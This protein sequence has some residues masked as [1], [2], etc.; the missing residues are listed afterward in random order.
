MP[1]KTSRTVRPLHQPSRGNPEGGPIRAGADVPIVAVTGF[2]DSGKTT[3]V[4]YIVRELSRRGYRVGTFKHCHYGYDLDRPGKDSYRHRQAG[5]A[6][7]VLI[8]PNGFALLSGPP[9]DEDPRVLA[10]W[11]LPDAHLILAEG[12]HDLPLPRIEIAERDGASRPAHPDGEVLARL[13]VHFGSREIADLC[14]RLEQKYLNRSYA[15]SW[16]RRRD[17]TG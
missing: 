13:P 15:I 17:A 1:R 9:P 14:D 16:R 4:E 3:A 6:G 10:A 7:T 12:F 8:S 2:R 5:A 11:L